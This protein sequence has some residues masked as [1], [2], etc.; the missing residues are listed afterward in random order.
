MVGG[1][2][3]LALSTLPDFSSTLSL[4]SC[5][6]H[7]PNTTH[8]QMARRLLRFI[9]GSLHVELHYCLSPPFS[10]D[11]FEAAVHANVGGD[12]ATRRS[13]TGF[14]IV[15]SSTAIYWRS[16]GKTAISLSSDET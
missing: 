7:N 15:V 11:H 9:S 8:L 16:K 4:L 12:V 1:V 14:H 10:T 6:L 13:T 2:S 3:Y 5:H